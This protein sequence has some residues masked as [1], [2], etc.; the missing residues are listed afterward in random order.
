MS[1]NAVLS[2]FAIFKSFQ[3]LTRVQQG[4]AWS[5]SHARDS[6]EDQFLHWEKKVS[7]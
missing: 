6:A 2:K 7:W 4:G 1:G 5:R 3:N